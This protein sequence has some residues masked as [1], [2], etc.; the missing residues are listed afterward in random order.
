MPIATLRL[1]GALALI[2]SLPACA[3]L[4][5]RLEGRSEI[6]AWEATDLALERKTFGSRSAWVYSF[7]LLVREL[8]G[9]GL[10]FTEIETQTY[11]PGIIPGM[12]R[13]RG[14]WRL[15]LLDEFRIPLEASLT[16]HPSADS[17]SGTNV[18]IPLWRI[19]MTGRDD[20][21][22]AVTVVIDITLPPD[23]PTPPVRTSKSA[24][25]ITLVPPKPPAK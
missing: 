3:T 19:Q 25:A 22:R 10:T 5:P 14:S 18:P 1:I 2:V 20:R 24:R 11:Q 21:D 8:R 17:C 12:A 6:V 13:Y 4:G 7:E 16:C 23:P 9:T 15:G